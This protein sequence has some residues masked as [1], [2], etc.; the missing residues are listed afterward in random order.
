AV[1][2]SAQVA[3]THPGSRVAQR[4]AATYETYA[5]RNDLL[6]PIRS[7]LPV[8][9]REIGFIAGSNDTDYSLWRPFGQRRVVYLRHS[10]GAFLA[11]PEGIEWLVVKANQWPQI[12]PLPLAQWAQTN[13]FEIVFSTNIVELVSWG[14]E[15]WTLLH[16][17]K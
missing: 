5:R 3:Q 8:Q 14:P 4:M 17:Q 6:A 2:V 1:S 10:A 12:C 13:H 7:Q 9:A 15:E 16:R 11:H